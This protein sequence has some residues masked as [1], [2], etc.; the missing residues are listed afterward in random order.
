MTSVLPIAHTT[1]AFPQ[2]FACGHTTDELPTNTATA[3]DIRAFPDVQAAL[4]QHDPAPLGIWTTDLV[5]YRREADPD[6][7]SW[8]QRRYRTQSARANAYRREMCPEE[9]L[10]RRIVKN[11]M[12]DYGVLTCMHVIGYAAEAQYF[13][14]LQLATGAVT[15]Q[16]STAM[17]TTGV[18]AIPVISNGT[19]FTSGMIVTLGYGT[20]NAEN[21]TVGSGSTSTSVVCSATTKT[22]SAN[23]WVVENPSTSDNPS[24][25][26]NGYDSG[27]LASGA[28]TYSG[29]GAGGRQVKIIYNFPANSGAPGS[30]YTDLWLASAATIASNTTAAHLTSSP[31]IVNGTTGLDVTYTDNI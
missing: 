5:R 3:F 10:E 14:H 7:Q 26:S 18:T 13:N 24:S 22:H 16:V 17:G 28:Y 15:A 1:V 8:I 2:F 31:W 30:G 4:S 25:V 27:A 29:T 21:V 11:V 19:S 23:D 9:I 20:A 6:L 12:T